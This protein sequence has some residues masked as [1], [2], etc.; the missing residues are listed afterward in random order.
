M[1]EHNEN[2]KR[3][4]TVF[5]NETEFDGVLEF[6]DRLII[7]G[8]FSGKIIAPTGDLEIAKNAVCDVESISAASIVVSGSVKG[9]MNASERI[10]IC[11]GSV[12]ESDV[13]TARIRIANNVDFNGQVSMLEDEPD[14]NLFSLASSEFKQSMIIHSDV[15]K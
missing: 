14:I 13:T 2:G 7:T 15:I 1:A 5:G 10:E 12:V 11:S 4:I 3:N 9:N 8:K 6:K